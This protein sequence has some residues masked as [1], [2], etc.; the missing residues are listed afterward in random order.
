MKNSKSIGDT[1]KR[2]EQNS[3][4]TLGEELPIIIR[5]DGKNF[6]RRTRKLCKPFDV[7][8]LD[9]MHHVT[10]DLAKEIGGNAKAAY[11]QSDEISILMD[12]DE[13]QQ[14]WFGG[15]KSKIESL[16][17]SIATASFAEFG[18]FE[19]PA[20]F[21]S[22]AFN[23]PREE[24]NDYFYWRQEDW[25]RNMVSMAARAHMSHNQ[26]QGL[27]TGHLK[28]L[29]ETECQYDIKKLP[30]HLQLGAFFCKQPDLGFWPLLETPNF[31]YE[32]VYE[33]INAN[34]EITAMQ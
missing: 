16:T 34:K 9:A 21:D 18:L 3:A 24:A 5:I 10:L 30:W 17:A 2:Y 22:R 31:Y 26:M 4:T 29:L 12:K 6:S 27:S 25:K 14:Y 13:D 32:N 15:K 1:M 19:R 23:V 11:T 8:L 20:L 7:G 33:V 28:M